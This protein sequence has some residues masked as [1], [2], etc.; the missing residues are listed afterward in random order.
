MVGAPDGSG[1]VLVVSQV[2]ASMDIGPGD[3]YVIPPGH[4]ARVT[5]DEAL[6]DV[7]V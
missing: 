1:T 7:E 2:G 3:A 4:D 5:S 6:V